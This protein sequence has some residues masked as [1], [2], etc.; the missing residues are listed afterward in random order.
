MNIPKD[1]NNLILEF[2]GKEMI[3]IDQVLVL[4]S[5]QFSIQRIKED[6]NIPGG[7]YQVTVSDV[8]Y[9]RKLLK[10]RYSKCSLELQSDD[11]M[12]LTISLE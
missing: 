5:T 4:S 1:I 3:K 10:S 6:L 11:T 7:S 2:A 8:D 12:Q 9:I